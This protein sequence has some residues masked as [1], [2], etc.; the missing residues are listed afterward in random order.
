MPGVREVLQLEEG[1]VLARQVAQRRRALQV[2]VSSSFSYQGATED[3]YL[4]NA[5]KIRGIVKIYCASSSTVR[6]LEVRRYCVTGE[7]GQCG[8]LL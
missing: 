2:S 6:P 7:E 4:F 3:F 5:I 8:A 1:L